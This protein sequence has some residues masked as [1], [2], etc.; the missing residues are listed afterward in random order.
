MWAPGPVPVGGVPTSPRRGM[1]TVTD[2]LIRILQQ[3]GSSAF[4]AS[5]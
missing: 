5:G 1:T 4:T 2:G 3:A